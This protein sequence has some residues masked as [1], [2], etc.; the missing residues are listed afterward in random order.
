MRKTENKIKKL[1]KRGENIKNYAMEKLKKKLVDL[2]KINK[3][4]VK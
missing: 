4:Q 2:N 3:R 1:E